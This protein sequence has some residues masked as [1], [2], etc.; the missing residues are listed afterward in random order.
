[1]SA[2]SLTSI[3]GSI[4]AMLASN[5]SGFRLSLLPKVSL[6]ELYLRGS[7]PDF[8]S[9]LT[10]EA[11]PVKGYPTR[12]RTFEIRVYLLLD[13]LTFH[14]DESHQPEA[15]GSEAPVA[16]LQTFS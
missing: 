13:E 10:P 14:V 4:S 12:Q 8:S 6:A 2:I 16:Y 7:T 1:M 9:G 11:F 15:T 5:Q 3:A